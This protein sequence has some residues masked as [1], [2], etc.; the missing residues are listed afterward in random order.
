MQ[1][2]HIFPNLVLIY[3]I[4][5]DIYHLIQIGSHSDLFG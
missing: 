3:R 5:E 4:E 2:L 1:E